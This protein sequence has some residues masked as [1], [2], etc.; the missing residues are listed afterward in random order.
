VTEGS[1]VH[2]HMPAAGF[3]AENSVEP[4]RKLS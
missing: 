1:I 2:I 4:F 3:R